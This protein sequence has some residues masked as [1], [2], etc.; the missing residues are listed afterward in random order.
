MA[1]ERVNELQDKWTEMVQFD[2]EKEKI[3]K[4][5]QSL[6]NWCVTAPEV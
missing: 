1:E 4:T 6:S 5:E 3:K 2:K